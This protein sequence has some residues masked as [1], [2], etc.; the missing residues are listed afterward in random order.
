M[1]FLICLYLC[2]SFNHFFYHLVADFDIEK[3]IIQYNNQ[4][5]LLLI[6]IIIFS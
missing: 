1:F 5:L 2:A 4:L 3:S 6:I